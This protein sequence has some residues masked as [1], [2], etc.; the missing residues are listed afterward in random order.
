VLPRP[1]APATTLQPAVARAAVPGLIYAK[2]PAQRTRG[3]ARRP[4]EQ[5]RS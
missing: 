4:A 3:V 2:P 5:G 1:A